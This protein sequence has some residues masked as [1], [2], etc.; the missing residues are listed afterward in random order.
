MGFEIFGSNKKCIGEI[1]M[2]NR[3]SELVYFDVMRTDMLEF[4]P[5]EYSKVLEVGCCTGNFRQLLS[6]PHEYWGCELF[7]E[8]ASIAKTKLDK[9]LVGFYEDVVNEIPD[10][11]FDLIIANDV[12]EHMEL[13][14]N[15]LQSIKRK[16]SANASIILSIPN[17]RYIRNLI[18]LLY[19]KDWEYKDCGILDIT[20]LRFFTQKSIVRLLNEN[21]FE[22]EKIKGINLDPV[23]IKKRYLLIYWLHKL[24]IGSDI[25][26]LRFGVRAKKL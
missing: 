22:I 18:E 2:I 5:S 7:K 9:V 25:E 24:V 26:F 10:N 11:Y 12:I 8:A 14:W 3:R 1:Y 17:V 13:P 20:H 23:K 4:L 15:F 19:K 16:M 6:K 21:G